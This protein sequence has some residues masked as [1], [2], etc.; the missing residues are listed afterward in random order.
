MNISKLWHKEEDTKMSAEK[1]I[2]KELQG[3][4]AE[5]DAKDQQENLITELTAKLSSDGLSIDDEMQTKKEL[6]EAQERL[7]VLNERV[8]RKLLTEDDLK[9]YHTMLANEVLDN[10]EPL[11][12]EAYELMQK[13]IEAVAKYNQVRNKANDKANSVFGALQQYSEQNQDARD[14][15][16]R[17]YHINYGDYYLNETAV[18]MQR[19]LENTEPVARHE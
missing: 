1:V 9:N 17:A 10:T 7:A 2:N 6:R 19:K 18:N 12:L 4:V 11:R 15:F 8:S 13:Y 3:L 16:S 14:M 5:V